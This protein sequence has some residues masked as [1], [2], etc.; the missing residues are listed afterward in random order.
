[1]FSYEKEENKM[2]Q[3]RKRF[4]VD[5]PQEEHG[6]LLVRDA[7]VAGILND[8]GSGGRVDLCVIRSNST[9]DYLRGYAIVEKKRQWLVDYGGCP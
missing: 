3:S 2:L 9:A 5:V 1:M 8:A 4:C 7:V 6:K